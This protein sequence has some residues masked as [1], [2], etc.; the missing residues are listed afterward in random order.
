MDLEKV[1]RFLKYGFTENIDYPEP[2]P[3][4][5]IT[6][7]EAKN[8]LIKLLVLPSDKEIIMAH[9]GSYTGAVFM[10]L[11]RDRNIK[12]VSGKFLNNSMYLA[13]Y[14]KCDFYQNDFGDLE[15]DLIEM[16]NYWN[17][18]RCLLGDFY[19]YN[20]QRYFNQMG[21][22]KCLCEGGAESLMV[23]D[24]Y[25]D[26]KKIGILNDSDLEFLNLPIPSISLRKDTQEDSFSAIHYWYNHNVST[27]RNKMLSKK[28]GV[29]IIQPFLNREIELFCLSLPLELKINMRVLKEA[30][31]LPLKVNKMIDGRVYQNILSLLKLIG[32]DSLIEKYLK[33]K[34]KKI[35]KILN[36]DKVNSISD[37]LKKWQL[38]N[39]SINIELDRGL[40]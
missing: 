9:S 36:Y 19:T 2:I 29:D 25:S 16:H 28:F 37:N 17:S 12:V 33:N 26:F 7:D 6:M 4:K 23:A 32:F 38:L 40:V 35:F 3:V 27:K 14:F 8:K 34:N 11:L 1:S 24:Y 15:N 30:V 22:K 31:I 20:R 10:Y 39:L 13:G 21:F 5:R 18:P